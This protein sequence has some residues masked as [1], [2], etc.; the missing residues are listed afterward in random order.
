MTDHKTFAQTSFDDFMSMVRIHA[1]AAEGL[2]R[3]AIGSEDSQETR[4]ELLNAIHDGANSF[5]LASAK[6]LADMAAIDELS[7]PGG[8]ADLL[9][10][11]DVE[12]PGSL[13][14]ETEAAS[15]RFF[16]DLLAGL[17]EEGDK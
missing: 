12:V 6:V 10:F 1:A 9:A 13:W 16:G 4:E 3:Q 14:S 7:D 15:D 17:D 8:V 2:Y 11:D 5:A